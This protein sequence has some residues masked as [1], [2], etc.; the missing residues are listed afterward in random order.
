MATQ[1][2][3]PPSP[4]SKRAIEYPMLGNEVAYA[5]SAV[6]IVRTLEAA[7]DSFADIR[8]L[9]KFG[10]AMAAMIKMIATTIRSSINEN[11]LCFFLM[12]SPRTTAAFPGL[13]EPQH[14]TQGMEHLSG[15]RLTEPARH[16]LRKINGIEAR[17]RLP[18]S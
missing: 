2:L 6:E 3:E 15:Q 9:M 16:N 10:I 5:V 11:P 8:E 14:T 13:S 18:S 12:G 1:L 4:R 7:E 17:M